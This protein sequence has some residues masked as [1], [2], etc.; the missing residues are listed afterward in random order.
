MKNYKNYIWNVFKKTSLNR[1]FELSVFEYVKTQDLK[2]S[3]LEKL[4]YESY[5]SNKSALELDE[6]VIEI[7]K[8]FNVTHLNQ[9]ELICKNITQ[10]CNYLTENDKKIFYDYGH[11]TLEGAKYLGKKIY[12]INWLK[13]N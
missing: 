9:V 7:S 11:Y 3:E 6:K 13:L 10:K 1:N 5:I 2:K 8:K 4:Y 12:E